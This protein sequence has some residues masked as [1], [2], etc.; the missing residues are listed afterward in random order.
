MSAS[1]VIYISV[2]LLM[3]GLFLFIGNFLTNTVMDSALTHE[4]L[5]SSQGAVDNYNSVKAQANKLDYVY[6]AFF[7]GLVFGLL[8]TGWLI[9]GNPIFM[10]FY[11]IIIIIGVLI[12]PILSNAFES[13]VSTPAITA[14]TANFPIMMFIMQYLPMF[15]AV[16]GLIGLLVMFASARFNSPQ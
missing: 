7:M 1:D 14:T 8:I 3:T 9:G 16:I 15:I 4:Q 11:I 10:F 12:S 2:V 13:F 5:N 6:F